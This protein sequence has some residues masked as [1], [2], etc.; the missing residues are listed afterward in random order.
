MRYQNLKE[1][2]SFEDPLPKEV[3]NEAYALYKIGAS[4]E[5]IEFM[6]FSKTKRRLDSSV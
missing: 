4:I 1:L 5:E 6:I 3:R 2:F